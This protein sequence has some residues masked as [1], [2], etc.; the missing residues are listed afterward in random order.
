MTDSGGEP[1]SSG[2]A[3]FAAFVQAQSTALHRTAYLLTGDRDAAQ[4]AVQIALASMY[5]V[6]AQRHAWENP[7]GYA[8][9]VVTRAVLASAR[10]RW[11]GERPTAELPERASPSADLA[12]VDERDALRRALLALPVKQ[13][14]AVVLR[15]YLDMSESETALAMQCPAGSVKSLT[16]RG[17][18]TLRAQLAELTP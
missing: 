16:S 15:H 13:R 7:A 5:R 9:R 10:R 4:D 12:S 3:E 11:R 8:H 18:Q 1:G 17:L 2:D 6:W 14:T